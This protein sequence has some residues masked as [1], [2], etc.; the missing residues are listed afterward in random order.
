MKKLYWII[1]ILITVF[2]GGYIFIRV[3]VLKT[4]TIEPDNTKT[5]SLIDLRPAIIAKLQ[6]IVKE[7]S[8]G[9][10]NLSI[11]RIEPHVL[12]SKLDVYNATLTPDTS[13]LQK[14]NNLH[15]APDDVFKISFDSLHID[16]FGIED[17]LHKDRMD[18]A[19]V[20]ITSP[21]INMYHKKKEYNKEKRKEDE[22][23]TLYQRLMKKMKSIQIDKIVIKHGT[24]INHDL[25]QKNKMTRFNDVSININHVLIDSSTQ[26][27]KSRF[28]FS[29]N[30]LLSTTDY[31]F[32]TPDSLYFF[33]AATISISSQQHQLTATNVHLQPRGNKEQFK[34]KVTYQKT[35]YDLSIPR[36]TLDEVDWY[37]FVNE[38]KLFSKEANIYNA[39][40][41]VYFDRSLPVPPT[42]DMRR[43]P[44]QLIMK[45]PLPI[46][47][48][49]INVHNLDLVYDEFNPVFSKGG[50]VYFDDLSGSITNVT[51]MP[52]QIKRNKFITIKG[53]ALFM[54][55]VPAT[56]AIRFDMSKYK[57]GN[58]TVDVNMKNLDSTIINPIAAPLGEFMVKNGF[59][60]DGT[61]HVE[62]DNYNSKVKDV[63]IYSSLTLIPLKKDAAN[64]GAL[65]K[66]TVT[67]F[68]ANTFL[69]KN[70]NPSKGE[71]T[72]IAETSHT[73]K[74]KTSF[75]S[76]IWK[77]IFAGILKTI[78]LPLKLADK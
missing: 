36:I 24:F 31:S 13:A 65:K 50:T 21:V 63:M 18:I 71:A 54:H 55:K 49:K 62:G 7:G 41:D 25:S 44:G 47:L 48:N 28:L 42:F 35:R 43:F 15:L 17:L 9:L 26:Y 45:I 64:P 3:S 29:K 11:D 32:P 53:K 76:F 12:E 19:S 8:N 74:E 68:I 61:A 1:A 56:A 66:K 37:D 2:I 73:R 40:L 67:G 33:K 4:K 75:F 10:Y 38:E 59:M 16:G 78:G 77:S 14:L 51:N 60:T 20:F 46:L 30:A 34:K 58:F 69:I 27:D 5:R 22:N 57:T 70:N 52:D 72:R 6:E 23:S 39:K